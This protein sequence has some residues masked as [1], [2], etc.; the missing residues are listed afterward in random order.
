MVQLKI[1]YWNVGKSYERGKLLLEQE[2]T[3]DIVAIQEPGRNLNGDIYRPRG[4][5]YFGVDCSEK[6]RAVIYVNKK[7]N[8]KDLDFQAGKDWTAVTFKNLRD[9]TTVYSIYSPILTQGTPEHQWG[10]PLLE[11]IE[12][13]PPAG[14][15]VA[16]GD[17]NLHHPDWDLEN[18]TS[19]GAARLLT[20]ARRWRLSLLTP[21]GEPTRLGNATRGERD[22]TIDHAWLSPGVEAEYWGAQRCEQTGSD[23][24]PQEIWVQVGRKN[25]K[26]EEEGG[27]SWSLMDTEKVKEASEKRISVPERIDTVEDLELA[28]RRLDG[29]LTS[30]A[31]EFVPHR[32]KGRGR[33]ANWWTLECKTATKEARRTYWEWF[34]CRTAS[35]WREFVEATM[36][37]KR[38]IAK[39]QQATWRD[40]VAEASKNP[41][42]LWPLE[43]WA[44]TRSHRP[45]DPPKLPA[46][47]TQEG[48]AEIGDHS[49]KAEILADRFFPKVEVPT[50]HLP[51]WTEPPE[52]VDPIVISELVDEEDVQDVLSRM[53]PNKAPGIDWYSNRFLKLCGQP[54][55]QAMA[56]LASASLRLGHFPQRFKDAKVVVLKKPGKSAAQQKLA[57]AWRPISLLSN[58][59]KILE[60]LVAKRLTQAAEEFNLLPEGQMGNRAGRS[61]E[62]AVRV[63]TDAVHTAWKLGAV[64]SLMLLD[65]KGAFDRVN[66]RWLLHTLW[67]MQLPTW[68]IRWVASFVAGR[69]GSLFFDDETSR[70][71]A[72]TA[73]VP[74]GSPLSPILF[75]LFITPLYRKLATIPNTITVGFADDTNVVAVAR[76]TEENC[77]TLQA[78]WEVCSGWAGARGM[79][80]EATKTE[81]MHF[82]RTRAPRT[83]TLQLGDTVLQPTESTRFLGVWLDRKLNY[84]AHAEA[85]KQKM[86]T[87]TNALTR[88]AAKTW[89][90]SFARAR[91]IYTKCIRSAIAYGASAFHQPTEVYGKPRG[92]VIGLAKYQTK[93]LRVVAGAYKATPVRNLETET[94]CPPLDLY[95]N[96]RVRAFEERLARTDQ[97]RFVRG[98][99][100][101][102]AS[103]VQ[104]RRARGRP[105]ADKPESGAAKARWAEA[106][107]PTEKLLAMAAGPPPESGTPPPAS[108]IPEPTAADREE[109]LED[110]TNR[111]WVS[112]YNHH[113]AAAVAKSGQRY[114]FTIADLN[115]KF[116]GEAI[117]RHMV[118]TKKKKGRRRKPEE[119]EDEPY[120]L[121]KA[122]SSLLVQARTE[123][124]GLRAFLHRRKVPDVLTP[125]CA[126]G[127]EKE[128]FAHI[129]LNCLDAE[130]LFWS[131]PDSWPLSKEELQEYLDDGVKAERILSWALRLGRLKEYRLAV[132]LEEDQREEL[133]RHS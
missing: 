88:L 53:A 41:S 33:R 59:G 79:E 45:A 14:N 108:Q 31:E 64:T 119:E 130:T 83:E 121:T 39:A 36:K 66:H 68:I 71:Y 75:I 98:T 11:F 118:G 76:T 47:Q 10:S 60:A 102:V 2:E 42:R 29:E 13:G 96:K 15:L 104:A 6:G 18:R 114:E 46:L 109:W 25:K 32:K 9:P 5:R 40:G 132:E 110:A 133:A 3:Y 77:R 50:D 26:A 8:L 93:C 112:R 35:N 122:K 61:T 12:A 100:A 82:T 74:Q 67:E 106:W 94:F 23:H 131:D 54:F 56:C 49:G 111:E 86:T 22:G 24:C 7:W 72:I 87:Q 62:F 107:A 4:G 78:A 120:P 117:Q 44:R 127:L 34:G 101:W 80:F 103:C 38:I 123:V 58:V 99:A 126:C 57:G 125:I 55:R 84:R 21:R 69:R 20:W 113:L 17:L 16:V 91:E 128:T 115:P 51:D 52:G 85:V 92:I 48:A 73:G 1:L 97:A 90:C 89:G 19:P 95:L 63:V 65:L 30:I 81:L 37:K 70:P 27:Y 124:I 105:P 116:S 43:R 129:V 28:F